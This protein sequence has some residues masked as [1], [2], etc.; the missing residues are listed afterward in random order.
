[1]QPPKM[2]R[3]DT[4]KLLAQAFTDRIAWQAARVLLE[5]A[6]VRI[7]TSAEGG[8]E[9]LESVQTFLERH[10]APPPTVPE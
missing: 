8:Q 2:T 6:A 1:M 9:L 4:R 10:P 3:A 5:R 7:D